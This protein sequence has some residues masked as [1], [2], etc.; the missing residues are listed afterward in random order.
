[1]SLGFIRR[2]IFVEVSGKSAGWFEFAGCPEPVGVESIVP[3]CIVRARQLV[4][5]A[6]PLLFFMSSVI[7]GVWNVY[8]TSSVQAIRY[9]TH[10][11][12]GELY[13][14]CKWDVGH[15]G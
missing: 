13:I 8:V 2:V 9:D 6:L 1:M 3:D 5:D 10:S 14:N 4:V 7:S 11:T 15:E 12:N